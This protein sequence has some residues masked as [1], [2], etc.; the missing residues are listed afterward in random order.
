MGR[1]VGFWLT[2]VSTALLV[3]AC[4]FGPVECRPG[5]IHLY[6]ES[7]RLSKV[8]TIDA[9]VCW[10]GRCV[11]SRSSLPPS[12]VESCPWDTCPTSRDVLLQF[13]PST[14]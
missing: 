4:P 8:A 12:T 13:D 7:S 1:R 5:G 9:R 3:S 10:N 6:V 2:M 14:R 11:T